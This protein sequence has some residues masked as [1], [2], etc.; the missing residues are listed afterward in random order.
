MLR[1]VF[2]GSPDLSHFI[3]EINVK[4]GRIRHT[5]TLNLNDEFQDRLKIDC[6]FKIRVVLCR[7][8]PFLTLISKIK[9]HVS[10]LPLTELF[11]PE[12]PRDW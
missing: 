7:I 1:S 8:R 11:V 10:E 9:W 4:K 5:T 3:F 12:V 6:K 2:K